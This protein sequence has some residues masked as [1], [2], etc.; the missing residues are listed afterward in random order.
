MKTT[1]LLKSK[2][3][4]VDCLV[5][6]T[7]VAATSEEKVRQ[8]LLARMIEE[9]GYPLGNIAV[10]KQLS[11]MPHILKGV[12]VLPK[13]RADIVCFASGIHVD[14][15]FYPLLLIE[16]KAVPLNRKVVE[17]VIGYNYFMQ[18]FFIAV[19]NQSEVVISGYSFAEKRYCFSSGLPSYE[20]LC[21]AV[22]KQ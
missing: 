17:Q 8:F 11:Q 13:R 5:R 4:A 16:C 20:T 15:P 1:A 21:L 22:R 12:S 7:P 19:A 3:K 14:Y 6:K 2:P 10:E 18:A 9:L